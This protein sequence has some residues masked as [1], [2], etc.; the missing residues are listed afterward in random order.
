MPSLDIFN[1]DAFSVTGLT[2]AI[3]QPIEGQ[4]TST[5]LDSLFEEEG[6]TTTAVFIER[7]ADQL[8]LVPAAERG[9][10]ADPTIADKRDMIPFSTIHLPTRGTIMADEVQGI[11][12]F[13]SESELES[14]EN[15]VNKRLLKMRKRLD[16]TIRY[17]R[18]G[19]VTGK[20]YDADGQRVLLDVYDR[21]QVQQ[22]TVAMGLGTATTKVLAK[23]SDA[24]RRA[25]DV[26]GG[27]G[28]VTGW[29]AICGRSFFDDFA[30]HGAVAQAF[31]R[32]QEGIFLRTDPR[33]A[34]F[35]YGGVYWEEFYGKVGPVEFI[36][37]N[38]AYLVPIVDGLFITRFAPANYM[39]TV[40]TLG[41]PYYSSQEMLRHNKGVDLEAQS[42]PLNLCTMPRAIIKLTK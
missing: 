27:S 42:N 7:E 4:A 40:N 10:P 39:E 32:F 3:N 5:R 12:A 19:A 41:L 20:V 22:I 17:H 25:E 6:I 13:G 9:G 18:V 16:A 34:G 36:D 23:V 14:V 11:R 24:K 15:M 35:L 26:L 21:F 30:S 1:D 29:L 38:V 8:Y 31:D 33:A 28:L 2:A 37:T